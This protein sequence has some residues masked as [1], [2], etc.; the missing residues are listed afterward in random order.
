MIRHKE[1]AEQVDC[2]S[3]HKTL[4]WVIT[5]MFAM[6]VALMTIGGW[7]VV[8]AHNAVITAS[9]VA[10]NLRVEQSRST[11]YREQSKQDMSELKA[12]FRTLS[13][14]QDKM[15]DSVQRLVVKQENN[16]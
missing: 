5:T 8:S 16:K 7:S 1:Q 15:N 4:N 2:D 13:E 6:L 14:K 9:D 11:D 3:R 12:W 10:S